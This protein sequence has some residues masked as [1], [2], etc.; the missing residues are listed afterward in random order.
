MKAAVAVFLA[1][2]AMPWSFVKNAE[3]QSARVLSSSSRRAVLSL[4]FGSN[5]Q[6]L[7]ARVGQQIEI[8][9]GTVGPAQYGEPEISSPA[10]RLVSTALNMPPNPGGASFTYIFEAVAEGEAQ[11]KVPVLNGEIA[12]AADARNFAVT[13]RVGPA[14]GRPAARELLLAPDQANAAPWQNAWTNLNNGVRQTFTPSRPRLTG[15]EVELVAA[16]SGPASADISLVVQNLEGVGVA[17]ISKTVPAA[18]CAHVLFILPRGG[19]AVSPGQVYSIRLTGGDNVFGW[20]YVVG[21]YATGAAS[22]NGKPLLP[23]SRSTFLFRTFGAN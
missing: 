5:G 20:K 15:V 13:L 7:E 11:I 17:L 12:P 16:N 3:C 9:L 10:V 14:K 1:L 22:F 23:G 8:S 19:L 6:R 21:G 2:V 4:D 18:D